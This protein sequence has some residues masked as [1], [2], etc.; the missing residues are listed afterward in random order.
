MRAVPHLQPACKGKLWHC[1]ASAA[2][3]NCASSWQ[4]QP[5]LQFLQG[6]AICA[7]DRAAG[8]SFKSEAHDKCQRVKFIGSA[9]SGLSVLHLHRGMVDSMHGS[10]AYLTWNTSRFEAS[11]H[12]LDAMPAASGLQNQD[13]TIVSRPG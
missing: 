13:A 10:L 8:K 11:R 2:Q 4:L 1:L 12:R 3:L 9:G 6:G 5:L 7:L